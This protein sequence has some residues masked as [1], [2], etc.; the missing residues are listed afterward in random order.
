MLKACVPGRPWIYSHMPLSRDD[1][2]KIGRLARLRLA[3]EELSSLADD[4][5]AI[6]GYI[7]TLEKVDTEGVS[8]RSQ[9]IA[10]E[11]V[12][13]EDI[14]KPCLPRSEALK[15]APRHDDEHFL[16]PKVIG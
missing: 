1:I 16:V 2:E 15:N 14:E 8:A 13:R 9:F 11:N 7:E 5:A 12:F 3:E 4:M 6:V 10:V